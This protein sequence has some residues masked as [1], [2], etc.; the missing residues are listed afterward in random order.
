MSKCAY[1]VASPTKRLRKIAAVTAPAK[2][3]LEMWFTSAIF[4]SRSDP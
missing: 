4:E 3:P 1:G 2:D